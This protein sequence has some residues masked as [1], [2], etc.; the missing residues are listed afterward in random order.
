MA[1]QSVDGS[2]Q[3]YALLR[4]CSFSCAQAR[5]TCILF[6]RS[7]TARCIHPFVLL[8][9]MLFEIHDCLL[10][11]LSLS[12]SSHAHCNAT[13]NELRRNTPRWCVEAISNV[14]HASGR[15][16]ALYAGQLTSSAELDLMPPSEPSP[17]LAYSRHQCTTSPL[18]SYSWPGPDETAFI[19]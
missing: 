1:Q 8:S 15:I 18:I 13:P 19:L 12:V 16:T 4:M 6:Y 5:S 2:V 3:I 11:I 17:L 10:F 7:L 14:H 9:Q